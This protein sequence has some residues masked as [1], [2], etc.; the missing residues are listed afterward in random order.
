MSNSRS[1]FFLLKHVEGGVFAHNSNANVMLGEL[2]VLGG[3][4]H[5]G[6]AVVDKLV[7]A[8]GAEG[9]E[10]LFEVG[11]C[12][13]AAIADGEG[14]VLVVISGGAGLKEMGAGFVD[15]TD[16]EADAEGAL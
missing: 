9:L 5:R 12:G 6:D 8:A 13:L 10:V 7:D 14:T 3:R 1:N 16:E 15:A 4:P 2:G 11:F